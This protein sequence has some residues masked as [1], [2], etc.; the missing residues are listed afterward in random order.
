MWYNV[1]FDNVWIDGLMYRLF[2]NGIDLKLQKLIKDL[3]SDAECCVKVCGSLS[4]WFTISQGVHPGAPLSMM[5][6]QVFMNLGIKEIKC[7]KIGAGISN[8][9]LPCPTYD[10]LLIALSIYA[11]PQML[12][13]AL[14]FSKKWW[15]EFSAPKSYFLMYS[16]IDTETNV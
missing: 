7:M 11:M 10:L 15:L 2:E 9:H 8:I 4:Q 12:N 14:Y 5:L 3:Y 6:F 1:A 16:D 13:I